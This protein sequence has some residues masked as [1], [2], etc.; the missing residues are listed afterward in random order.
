MTSR[1]NGSVSLGIVLQ[2]GL[3]CHVWMMD[4]PFPKWVSFDYCIL[5][6]FCLKIGLLLLFLQCV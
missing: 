5:G 6:T 2:D 3:I 1:E 4:T